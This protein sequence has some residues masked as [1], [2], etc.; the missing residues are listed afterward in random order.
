MVNSIGKCGKKANVCSIYT[1]KKKVDGYLLNM[2]LQL[3]F[4]SVFVIFYH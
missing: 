2:E 3:I 1:Q 4:L